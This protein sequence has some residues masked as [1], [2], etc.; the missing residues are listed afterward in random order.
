MLCVPIDT[1]SGFLSS[2]KDLADSPAASASTATASTEQK[3]KKAKTAIVSPD[4]GGDVSDGE[5]DDEEEALRCAN[6][7]PCLAMFGRSSDVLQLA[8]KPEV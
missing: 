4:V 2:L 8:S 5:D 6:D 1:P 7:Q 3:K